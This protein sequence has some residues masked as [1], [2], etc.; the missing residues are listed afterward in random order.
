MNNIDIKKYLS[1]H[2]LSSINTLEFLAKKIVEGFISGLHKSP[3]HGFSVEFS[4]H[5]PYI[6]GDN[7]RFMDWKVYARTDRYYIKQFEEETNLRCSLLLDI[8]RSMEFKSAVLSKIQYASILTAALSYILLKQRDATGLVLFDEHIKKSLPPKAVQIY[9]QEILNALD[10]IEC[11]P[12]TNINNALHTVAEKIKKRGLII[13]ISDLLD[14]PEKILSGIKHLRYNQH[15]IIVFH[16]VDEQEI[17]FNYN[18]EFVFVDLENNDKI[19][20]DSRFIQE[21]YT[22]RFKAHCEFFKTKFQDNMVDYVL[23]K[24]SESIEK[25]LYRFFL[26]R[27]NLY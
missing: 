26:K 1:T 13:L 2:T 21:D 22:Q 25:A 7:L 17:N 14:D 15:E 18:G 9:I 8:S 16:I 24:T 10:T 5:K 23:L 6:Q 20:T 3:F 11:G 27:Q 12:D 4:Q 19:K